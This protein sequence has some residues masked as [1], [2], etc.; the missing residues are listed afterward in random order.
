[1]ASL[2]RTTIRRSTPGS[3]SLSSGPHPSSAAAVLTHGT[4]GAIAPQTYGS[5]L[6]PNQAV[7]P[8]RPWYRDWYRCYS[9]TDYDH[10]RS[11]A[12]QNREYMADQL[13]MDNPLPPIEELVSRFERKRRFDQADRVA[14][15]ARQNAIQHPS[16]DRLDRLWIMVARC[17]DMRREA[18]K[19]LK[20]DLEEVSS[21]IDTERWVQQGEARPAGHPE[22]HLGRLLARQWWIQELLRTLDWKVRNPY[23]VI[24][25]ALEESSAAQSNSASDGPLNLSEVNVNRWN[26]AYFPRNI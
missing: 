1:M 11:A 16:N 15:A 23:R 4:A 13:Q 12:E 6:T 7:A 25:H 20:D 9:G 5:G 8:E 22:V 17:N 10:L 3:V 2:P 26:T 24:Q 19:E 18:K 21:I 14:S